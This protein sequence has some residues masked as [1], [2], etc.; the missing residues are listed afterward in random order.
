MSTRRSFGGAT[1][2]WRDWFVRGLDFDHCQM[3]VLWASDSSRP[4]CARLV[5]I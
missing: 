3:T 4:T 2:A 5:H 1:R